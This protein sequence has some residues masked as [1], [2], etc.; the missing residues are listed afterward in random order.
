MAAKLP[1]LTRKNI[2]DGFTN[3]LGDITSRI[4]EYTGEDYEIIVNFDNIWAKVDPNDAQL[5]NYLG[6]IAYNA[7]EIL[8]HRLQEMTGKDDLAK[9]FFNQVVAT[10]KI[11]V[12]VDDLE[13][14]YTTSRVKD[15]VLEL[16]YKTGFYGSNTM[17]IANG[18]EKTL[19]KSFGETNKG[20]LPGT[21]QQS[22]Q[23]D[24]LLQKKDVEEKI[25]EEM[26]GTELT[27]VADPEE[28]WRVAVGEYDKLKKSEQSEINLEH[29]SHTMGSGIHSYFTCFLHQLE[30]R[31]KQDDL[32]VEGF[33]DIVD[34]KQIIF[35]VVPKGGL[36]ANRKYNDAIYEDGSLVIRTTPQ[37]WCTNTSDACN[38]I[39]KAL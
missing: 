35:K 26:L 31:F 17:D 19:D 14:G 21:A 8:A 22:F 4:K 34:Q 24:F 30:T 18:L 23:R 29:I 25:K 20:Q 16:V 37:Y 38:E 13:S 7:L 33:L 5:S 39:D 15:G 27:L 36:S 11:D 3:K 2:R 1:L 10:R 6:S 12:L 28:I 32:M 9:D